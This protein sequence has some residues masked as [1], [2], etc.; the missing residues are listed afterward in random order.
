MKRFGITVMAMLGFVYLAHASDLP[1]KEQPT[2]PPNC[3]GSLWG[4]LNTSASDCP[5]TYAGFTLYGTLDMGAGYN[6]AGIRFGKNYFKGVYY[7]ISAASNGSRWSWF[8]NA[9]GA[10]LVGLEMEE[11]LAGDW[12]LIGAA[13][14]IY[15]PYSLRVVNDLR[16]LTDNNLKIP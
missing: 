10:S 5:L 3:Y 13:E 15:N 4:W 1:T 7:G 16:S 12:L 9:E 6:T 14:L 8:P 2:P 11:P